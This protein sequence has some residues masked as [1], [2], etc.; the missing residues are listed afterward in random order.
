MWL[1][2]RSVAMPTPAALAIEEISL[3]QEVEGNFIYVYV[4]NTGSTNATVVEV[5]VNNRTMV[6]AK[7]FALSGLYIVGNLSAG[8]R[9]TVTSVRSIWGSEVSL[10]SRTRYSEIKPGELLEIKISFGQEG[11]QSKVDYVVRAVALGGV[12]DEGRA[13]VK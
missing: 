10:V 5:Y 9:W 7:G 6:Y 2:T 12:W 11:W 4:R 1:E 3:R 13:S 8:D